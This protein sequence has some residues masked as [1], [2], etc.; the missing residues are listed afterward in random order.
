MSEARVL[1]VVDRRVEDDAERDPVGQLS[2]DTMPERLL[3][4]G[5]L[6]RPLVKR[7][8]DVLPQSIDIHAELLQLSRTFGPDMPRKPRREP[9]EVELA[10]ADEVQRAAH[11]RGLVNKV[12]GKC[13][14]ELLAF[15]VSDP[16]P[17][18]DVRR[19]RVLRLHA[20]KALDRG[21]PVEID[22]LEQHLARERPAIQLTKGDRPGGGLTCDRGAPAPRRGS[23]ESSSAGT[24]ETAGWCSRAAGKGARTRRPEECAPGL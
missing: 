1:V 23:G 16:R 12:S 5:L 10:R 22:A 11:Q 9:E 15:E 19:R 20:G 4:L 6:E 13:R 18:P 3:Q 7:H 24:R 17:K 8:Q 21:H 14:L 2:R